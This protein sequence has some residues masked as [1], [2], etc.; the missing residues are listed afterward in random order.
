LYAAVFKFF[1]SL[2]LTAFVLVSLVLASVAGMFWDQTLTLGE[3]LAKTKASPLMNWA[4]VFFELDDV[5]HSWWY[6]IL[7]LLLALNLIACSIERL[8]KIWIDIHKPWEP[9]DDPNLLGFKLKKTLT[10]KSSDVFKLLT[11]AV[12]QRPKFKKIDDVQYYFY[13]RNKYG[14]L[15]VYIIHIALLLIMYGATVSTLLSVDG[16]MSIP[17]TNSSRFVQLRGPGGLSYSHDLGFRVHCS[18]FRLRTFVD[19]S[20]LAFESDLQIFEDGIEK[21]ILEKTIRVND[22]LEYKGYTFYQASYQ[23]MDSERRVELRL[24]EH[25][26]EG[27]SYVVPLR[28]RLSVANQILSPEE[29]IDD[30]GGLG[31][32]LK[33][34]IYDG[35]LPKTSF[36]VFRNYP[37]FD[38]EVRRGVADVSFQGIDQTFQTGLSVRKSPGLSVVFLGFFLLFLGIIVAFCFNHIRTYVRVLPAIDGKQEVTIAMWSRRHHQAVEKKFLALLE[39]GEEHVFPA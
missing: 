28:T 15:G 14:R 39:R 4:L 6:S 16:V 19:G 20:P 12:G 36:Y 27:E 24:A 21:P 38:S 7:V 23:P 13:E 10:L 25:G 11:A 30:F 37:S 5:F 34:A 2:K 33:M 9:L 35:D 32:A 22:P 1:C 29:V 26:S 18:D 17:E 3:H 8:P 31:P